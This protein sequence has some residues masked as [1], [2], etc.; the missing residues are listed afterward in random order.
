MPTCKT[1]T[2]MRVYLYMINGKSTGLIGFIALIIVGGHIFLITYTWTENT[3]ISLFVT[4][5]IGYAATM[6]MKT[7]SGLR[8]AFEYFVTGVKVE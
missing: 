1:R 3:I 6:R 4:G 2:S 8:N 5:C 7:F